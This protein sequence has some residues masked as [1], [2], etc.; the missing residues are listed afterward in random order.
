MHATDGRKNAMKAP[1]Y[2]YLD[3]VILS[4][5]TLIGIGWKIGWGINVVLT[6]SS[7]R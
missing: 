7:W 3:I 4:G 5:V 2:S 6:P 1:E